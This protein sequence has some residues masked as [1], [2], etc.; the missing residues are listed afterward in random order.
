MID[1]S[2]SYLEK[3]HWYSDNN[4]CPK[5]KAIGSTEDALGITGKLINQLAIE[6]IKQF[7]L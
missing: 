6:P 3:L 2:S 5:L 7:I 4:F 1:Y